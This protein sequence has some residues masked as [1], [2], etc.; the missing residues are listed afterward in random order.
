[1]NKVLL[2]SSD[3]AW[4]TPKSLFD[5]LD[6]HF[7]FTLDPC[8]VR[9]NALCKKF[10]TAEED[11]L[12]QSWQG[13]RVFMNPPYGRDIS[14]WVKKAYTEAQANSLVV[15][16]LPART[17]TQWWHK[18]IFNKAHVLFLKGRLKFGGIKK[19]APFPSAV[20]IWWGADRLGSW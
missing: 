8:C 5:F 14:L 9:E 2:S 19:D 20:C 3:L 13:E 1:M 7:S 11:G 17:E 16:L 4:T 10:Y 18:Y 12:L 15:G 6:G